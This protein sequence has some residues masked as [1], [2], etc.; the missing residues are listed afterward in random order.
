MILDPRLVDPRLADPRLDLTGTVSGSVGK[1]YDNDFR[2]ASRSINGANSISYQ[3]DNDSLLTMAGSL[4]I[5]REVQKS[6]LISGST[7]GNLTTIRSYNG[8]AELATFD[9]SYTTTSLF[10]TQYTRDKLGR[11]TQ[12]IET[13]AGVTATT[14]YVYDLSGRL[15]SETCND[16]CNDTGRTNI[17]Y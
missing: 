5:A 13:I 15:I 2:I 12:K 3:Y 17:T 9:A 14:N 8:F 1:T 10:N 7:L 4:S 6:G 16:T 11:I